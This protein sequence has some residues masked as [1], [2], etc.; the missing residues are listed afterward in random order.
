VSCPDFSLDTF[1]EGIGFDRISIRKFLAE[2]ARHRRERA[3]RRTSE[4]IRVGAP[5]VAP[6]GA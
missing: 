1:L 3:L 2:D 4:K 6:D 5:I